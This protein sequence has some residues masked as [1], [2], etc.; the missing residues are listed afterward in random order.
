MFGFR[1]ENYNPH[2][3]VTARYY[4]SPSVAITRRLGDF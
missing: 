2:G 4:F 1:R 3:K